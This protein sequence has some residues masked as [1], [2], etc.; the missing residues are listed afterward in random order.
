MD[1]ED[2]NQEYREREQ[3]IESRLQEF[4]ELR[5][6]DSERWFKELVFV[7]L[8]SRSSAKDSWKAVEKLDELN[9][10][11]DGGE[12]EIAEVLAMEGVRYER[13]KSRYIVNNRRKL[14]RPTLEST[15][16]KLKLESRVDPENLEATR[17]RLV[18]GLKGVGWKGASHF[19]RNIG[20]GNGFAIVSGRITSK[21]HELG[22]IESLEQP[23]GKEE[24]L[25]VEERMRGLS[26]ELDIDI[27]ALDLVLWA[28]ETGE[29]FK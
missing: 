25:E 10:L 3:E 21:L 29:I 11:E 15:S 4:E 28:M 16:G 5:D 13:S 7:I 27:K 8:T 9:L 20:Y 18:D 23:S 26:R 14:S 6:A 22:V 12:E 2:V 19:L 1:T 17:E 24:Y